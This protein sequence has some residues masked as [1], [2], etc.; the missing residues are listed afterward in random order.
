MELLLESVFKQAY[1]RI[2]NEGSAVL[3]DANVADGVSSLWNGRL[4]KPEPIHRHD[5]KINDADG[6]MDEKRGTWSCV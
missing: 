1:V 3:G 6:V 5:H 2:E 4:H